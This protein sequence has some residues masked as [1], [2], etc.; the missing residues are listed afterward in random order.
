MF[1]FQS[2]LNIQLQQDCLES[3][4]SYLSLRRT[5]AESVTV[6]NT[7]ASTVVYEKKNGSLM[8]NVKD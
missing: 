5:S 2:L 7:F 6:Y 4:Y 1:G 3:K 8:S